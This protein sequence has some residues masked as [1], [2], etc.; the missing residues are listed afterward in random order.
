MVT[1]WNDGRVIA[2]ELPLTGP[3]RF[4]QQLRGQGTLDAQVQT[5]PSF[6]T[7][8]TADY[9]ARVLWPCKDGAPV[10]CYVFTRHGWTAARSGMS[11]RGL[12]AE[13]VLMRRL[14]RHTLQF[15]AVDQND[16]VRDLLRYGTGQATLFTQGGAV[17]PHYATESRI[18]WWT[19]TTGLSGVTRDRL[20]TTGNLQDGYP[21]DSRKVVGEEIRKLTELGSDVGVSATP[22]PELR[23]VP[24]RDPATADP[25]LLIDVAYPRV[26]ATDPSRVLIT[27][28][29]RSVTDIAYEGNG[30]E[31]TTFTEV[32]GQQVEGT[33][34]PFGSAVDTARMGSG[35]PYL[36]R[37]WSE[38]N[39][40]DQTNLTAKAAARLGGL[41]NGWRVVLDGT[42]PPVFGLHYA[43]GD[44]VTLSVLRDGQRINAVQ[45]IT[46]WDVTV[47]G[48]KETV[49]LSL[50]DS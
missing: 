27:H 41:A 32:G 37:A 42:V 47:D 30:D 23:A 5:H 1:A 36:A 20:V 11:V 10:G 29:S 13:A 4:T 31:L 24:Y 17:T 25:R 7:P 6:S 48:Y 39:V 38:T 44:Y 2:R 49:A 28:P 18:P 16:I 35:T 34:R 22:G 15:S 40:S 33:A 43:V 46:G 19:T 50:E 14:I 26:G 3:L 45:R 12:A 8:V 9:W 21:A